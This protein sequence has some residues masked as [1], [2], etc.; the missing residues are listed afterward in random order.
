MAA[1]LQFHQLVKPIL[2]SFISFYV[3]I[4]SIKEVGH[5]ELDIVMNI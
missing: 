4:Q 3:I 2:N 1:Y 5:K